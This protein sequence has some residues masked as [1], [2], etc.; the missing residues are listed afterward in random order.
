[1]NKIFNLS[2]KTKYIVVDSQNC[3]SLRT[4]MKKKKIR[5]LMTHAQRNRYP[6][7]LEKHKIVHGL[8]VSSLL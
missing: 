6:K 1:M 4:S 2:R 8:L 5:I 3:L 7:I